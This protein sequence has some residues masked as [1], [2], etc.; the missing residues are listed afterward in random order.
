MQPLL[1]FIN[2]YKP[3]IIKEFDLWITEFIIIL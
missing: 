1:F 3:N 2:L